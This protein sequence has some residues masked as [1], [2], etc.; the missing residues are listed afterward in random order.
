M[1]LSKLAAAS[2]LLAVATGPDVE[3]VGPHL[4]PQQKSAATQPFVRSATDC[5]MTR[6][7]SDAR[8]RR[9]DP[10]ARLGD[11]IVD[12]MPNCL[13][14]VHAMIDVYDRYFGEGAGEEFFM[15]PYLDVL[16]NLLL[17]RIKAGAE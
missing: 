7:L 14:P 16:P 9:D 17:K 13:T 1:I 6:V 11:L 8:F 3:L 4:S 5:I 2:L 15:G 12:A 10:G